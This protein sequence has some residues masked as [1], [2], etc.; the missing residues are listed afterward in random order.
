[1]K[2][3]RPYKLKTKNILPTSFVSYPLH[4]D[5]FIDIYWTMRKGKGVYLQ[6]TAYTKK[7]TSNKAFQ[8]CILLVVVVLSLWTLIQEWF[9]IFLDPFLYH[10]TRKISCAKFASWIKFW[11]FLWFDDSVF[12]IQFSFIDLFFNYFQKDK[13][14]IVTLCNTFVWIL[15]LPQNYRCVW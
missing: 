6:C 9:W 11:Y 8:I 4:Q 7:E 5:I 12:W 10:L 15:K 3:V 1:M 13:N 14:I 2:D